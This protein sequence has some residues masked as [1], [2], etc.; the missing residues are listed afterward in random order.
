MPKHAS[1]DNG[2]EQRTVLSRLREKVRTRTR[3]APNGH[4]TVLDVDVTNVYDF[5]QGN[6]ALLWHDLLQ[7]APEGGG[8]YDWL[9]HSLAAIPPTT[10]AAVAAVATRPPSTGIRFDVAK[11]FRVRRELI[12]FKKVL[13]HAN[14]AAADLERRLRQACTLLHTPLS[15]PDNDVRNAYVLASEALNSLRGLR[16]GIRDAR[17]VTKRICQ[18][19]RHPDC[20]PAHIRRLQKRHVFSAAPYAEFAPRSG[21]LKKLHQVHVFLQSASATATPPAAVAAVAAAAAAAAAAASAVPAPSTTVCTGAEA[22][23]SASCDIRIGT[24]VGPAAAAAAAV[25]TNQTPGVREA[26]TPAAHP[27]PIVHGGEDNNREDTTTTGGSGIV[28]VVG[29]V[30]MWQQL[31]SAMGSAAAAASVAASAAA[32]A[33]AAAAAAAPTASAGRAATSVGRAAGASPSPSLVAHVLGI[34]KQ[35]LIARGAAKAFMIW[36]NL[37]TYVAFLT[38]T[39]QHTKFLLRCLARVCGGMVVDVDVNVNVNVRTTASAT[40][41]AASSNDP[42]YGGRPPT[43]SDDNSSNNNNS[44]SSSS[45]NNN[46]N[47]NNNTVTVPCKRARV[48]ANLSLIHI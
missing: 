2:T 12:N 3:P 37:R 4:V 20:T 29:H 15:D 19:H 27:V 47:N 38:Q 48:V 32:T 6:V 25:V 24:A 10:T 14:K 35:I 45:N 30:C 46:N 42:G 39:I 23:D 1:D 16:S 18:Q 28:P 41:R 43:G 8:V 21:V 13:Y 17:N 44:S 26:T 5:E 22:P 31:D 7:L 34:S 36:S 33:A 9:R 40:T 11:A